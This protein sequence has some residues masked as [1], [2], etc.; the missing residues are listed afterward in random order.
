MK[1]ILIIG[2]GAMGAAFSVP[3]ISNKTALEEVVPWS[4]EIINFFKILSYAK[5]F[6]SFFNPSSNQIIK[7]Q[8][9]KRNTDTES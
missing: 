6:F 3:L 7:N 8:S 1:R 9:Y 4:I 5:M 2:A